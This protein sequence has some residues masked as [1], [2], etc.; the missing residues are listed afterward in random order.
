MPNFKKFVL[1]I[2]LGL[3]VILTV[4]P[5]IHTSAE[6]VNQSVD[7]YFK[8]EAKQSKDQEMNSKKTKQKAQ[9]SEQAPEQVGF[10]FGDFFRMIAALLFVIML[11]FLLLKFINK[12]NK[13]YQQGRMIENMGGTPLGGNRSVQ[14]VRVGEK[15]LV[16][17]IGDSVQVLNVI[18]E[19]EEYNRLIEEHNE[20]LNQQAA[21][22]DI[23]SKAM[24]KWNK[25]NL[26]NDKSS[27]S[28]I[29]KNQLDEIKKDRKTW[30]EE[31]NR[32][33]TERDE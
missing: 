3:T 4:G 19:K 32:K 31:L 10:S 21:P 2:L 7:D 13:G 18:D 33:G 14:L 1:A 24:N 29:L 30:K 22:V 17:G 23:I 20:K 6:N 28:S 9:N 12:K 16:L 26:E 15:I 27:F 5:A 25:R 11:L 8:Q